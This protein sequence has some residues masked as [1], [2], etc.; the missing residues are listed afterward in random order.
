V[1]GIQEKGDVTL[2]RHAYV[3]TRD[4]K[5]GIGTKLLLHLESMTK[6]PILIGTWKDASWAISFYKKNGYVQL[7]EEEKNRLL[8]KYW[9]ISDRQ[10]ETSVVLVNREK[11]D[12]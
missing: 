3:R 11:E 1:M 8:R 6:R 5:Q 2:I 10:V 4:Q 7:S 9:S 12:P